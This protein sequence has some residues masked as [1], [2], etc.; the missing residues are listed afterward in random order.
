[1]R[2]VVLIAAAAAAPSLAFAQIG[3]LPVPQVP[4]VGLPNLGETVGDTLSQTQS[5]ARQAM[6]ARELRVRD[7]LRRH[8]DV[9]ERDPNG[10]PIV[11]REITAWSP[12]PET[13]AAA[14][15]QGF[16][17]TE[18]AILEGLDERLVTLRAPA[19]AS[20]RSALRALRRIDPEGVFDFNHIYLES[21]GAPVAMQGQSTPGVRV[22]LIDGGVD[23][24]ALS[25]V[26]VRQR[27][28]AGDAAASA[29]GGA[30]AGLLTGP[31]A[32][33]FVADVY[34]GAATGGSA[35]A[36]AQAL[37]WM[38]QERVGVINV[39][40]V[41]PR[42]ATLQ[43]AIA[44]MVRRGHVIV[45]A[46]GNDGPSAA[47]LYPAAFPGV[48]G[49]TGVTARGRALLEAGR[50]PQVDFAA[51]GDSAAGRGTSFASPIVARTLARR[52]TAPS[53]ER[54]A[55]AVAALESV[56][57]DLGAPGRDDVYGAGLISGEE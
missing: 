25:G 52:L 8:R 14:Q 47:P 31:G 6:E 46:V 32:A 4:G 10:A 54:A 18:D 27:G 9:L 40:L 48:I 50:G 38:A 51:R 56:A 19:G 21:G 30:V 35:R 12:S 26:T 43:A 39:S 7:L 42:N 33:L 17:I 55:R 1:M 16:A 13:L 23:A 45:A 20:T 2:W 5:L 15:A 28:F 41:G 57:T 49:V 29:H 22:G 11:W 36:V 3:G 24:R 53:P 37:G 34:C 44:A